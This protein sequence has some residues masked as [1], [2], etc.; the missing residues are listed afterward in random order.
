MLIVCITEILYNRV[1]EKM[2]N[3]HTTTLEELEKLRSQKQTNCS[4]EP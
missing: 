1:M 2:Q 3:L 4:G